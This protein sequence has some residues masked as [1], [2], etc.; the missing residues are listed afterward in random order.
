MDGCKIKFS[1]SQKY[2][3][4]SVEL[5]LRLHPTQEKL[6]KII[7]R[8]VLKH[9]YNITK[10]LLLDYPPVKEWVLYAN[11]GMDDS[12]VK[13]FMESLDEFVKMD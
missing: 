2:L 9:G 4:D 5:E 1:Y 13:I 8:I 11:K 3:L 7:E 10:H 6:Q 12:G